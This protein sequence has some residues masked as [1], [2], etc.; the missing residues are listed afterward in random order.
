MRSPILFDLF[1]PNFGDKYV[2]NL[3]TKD[4]VLVTE[5]DLR[6]QTG[7]HSIQKDP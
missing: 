5:A 1:K 7:R 4:S 6:H 2:Q 3:S